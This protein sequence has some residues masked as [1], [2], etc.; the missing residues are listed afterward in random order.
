MSH[1]LGL[2]PRLTECFTLQLQRI[3]TELRDYGGYITYFLTI[4]LPCA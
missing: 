4:S 1:V 3:T 2:E